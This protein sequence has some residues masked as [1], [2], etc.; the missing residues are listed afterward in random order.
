MASIHSSFRTCG[1]VQIVVPS[2]IINQIMKSF[3]NIIMLMGYRR[4]DQGIGVRLLA[5]EDK[6]CSLLHGGQTD[7]PVGTEGCYPGVKQPGREANQSSTSHVEV[8]NSRSST[9][10]LSYVFMAWFLIKDRDKFVF[11]FCPH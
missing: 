4:D 2:D 8:K 6:N 7:Y 5:G 11:S 9:S 10:A 3:I 1:A